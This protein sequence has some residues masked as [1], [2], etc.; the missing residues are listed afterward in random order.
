MSEGKMSTPLKSD[1][2]NKR[3]PKCQTINVSILILGLKICNI[4]Y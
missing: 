4:S 2:L 1:L 3:G